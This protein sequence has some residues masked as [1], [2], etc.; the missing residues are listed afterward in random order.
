KGEGS[1]DRW[2]KRGERV[3]QAR[4]LGDGDAF[5]YPSRLRVEHHEISEVLSFTATYCGQACTGE[6]IEAAGLLEV[7]S[8]GRCRLVVGTS[9]EATGQYIRVL[10]GPRSLAPRRRQT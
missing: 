4:V 2:R 5:D 6:T 1:L 3:L 7:S 8:D 10:R 9:R